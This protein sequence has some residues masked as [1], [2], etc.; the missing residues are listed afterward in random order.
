LSGEEQTTAKCGGLSTAQGTIYGWVGDD[1]SNSNCKDNS[2]S[3][4]GMTTRKA[5]AAAIATAMTIVDRN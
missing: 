3:P 4:S 5:T 2:R 1:N